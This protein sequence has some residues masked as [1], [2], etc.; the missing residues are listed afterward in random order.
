VSL[1]GVLRGAGRGDITA[2]GI[3]WQATERCSDRGTTSRVPRRDMSAVPDAAGDLY[4]ADELMQQVAE[5]VVAGA[6]PGPPRRAARL[7]A[8]ADLAVAQ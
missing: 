7:V 3:V 4:R 5:P 6:K 8:S 1:I 2:L